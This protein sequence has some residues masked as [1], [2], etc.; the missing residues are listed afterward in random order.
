M[1]KKAL[2]YL[3]TDGLNKAIPFLL[4]PILTAYLTPG[5]YG[6]ITNFNLLFSVILVFVGIS[7]H[8]AISSNYYKQ[9]SKERAIYIG[10][11]IYI[12]F[13]LYIISST[14]IFLFSETIF[15]LIKI[16]IQYQIL[17]AT[18][19]FFQA[20]T[21][22]NVA[23]WRL[24][25]K[26][27]HFGVYNILQTAL[28][29]GVSLY[30]IIQLNQ[31]WQGRADGILLA[32][33]IF[34]ILSLYLMYR[35]N[36]LRFQFNKV[37]SLDILYFG[38]PLIPHALSSWI[39]GGIDKVYITSMIGEHANGLYSVGFQ[40]GMLVSFITIA[41]NNAIVP[42]IYKN[43][44][45]KTG[46]ELKDF[47]QKL[48]KFN[49][50]GII[51]LILLGII[52]SIIS[53]YVIIYLLDDRYGEAQIFVT[54]AIFAQ[55]FQGMY[56]LFVNYIFFLKKT[57]VLALITISCS[58]LQ[59]LLSYFLIKNYGAIGGAYSTTIISFFNF[60]CVALYSQKVF[61]LPWKNIT[62]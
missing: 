25:E 56:L 34:G 29:F 12:I 23:L 43:L 18:L 5:D 9:N 30:L 28:N 41:G 16:P 37:F 35:R 60:I 3:F 2:I 38:I 55:V 45:H 11:A 7:T 58:L 17:A 24:E 10:N 52:L 31:G 4:L 26:A 1:I 39:R 13:S 53:Y 47:K 36:Y 40:F 27:I 19:A 8:G 49:I 33:I 61:P 62:K 48:V 57:K 22:I 51:G 46:V 59:A 15:S 20:I 21:A 6:L 32:G 54:W 14:I 42:V 44:S 50:I